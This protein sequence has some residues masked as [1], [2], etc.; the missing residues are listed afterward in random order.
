MAARPARVS[1]TIAVQ[2]H[3]PSFW[4]LK[5]LPS[6]TWADV[7][8][9]PTRVSPATMPNPAVCFKPT[10][11][12]LGSFGSGLDS[13]SCD[14]SSGTLSPSPS[15][16]P[17]TAT[18]GSGSAGF[19]IHLPSCSNGRSAGHAQVFVSALNIASLFLHCTHFANKSES[20]SGNVISGTE[21]VSFSTNSNFET[22][23]IYW[24]NNS[25]QSVGAR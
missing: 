4:R 20:I 10:A 16:A 2:P 14:F 9:S 13:S 23:V 17:G 25:W 22:S 19:A 8:R 11:H 21:S 6:R 3:V 12:I 5:T 15:P 24:L 1:H 18:T 7:Q